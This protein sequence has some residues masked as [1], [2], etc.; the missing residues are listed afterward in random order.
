[1]ASQEPLALF[2]TGSL[3]VIHVCIHNSSSGK[4]QKTFQFATHEVMRRLL[5]G[6]IIVVINKDW[7]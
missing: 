5:E 7:G 1:M 6:V 3:L 4:S 2:S